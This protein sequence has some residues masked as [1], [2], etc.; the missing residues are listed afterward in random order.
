MSDNR[1]L[2][3][4]IE[5]NTSGTGA[6]FA[7]KAHE[8]GFAPVLVASDPQKYDYAD[9]PWLRLESCDTY[10]RGAL[11]QL[12]ARLSATDV[13]AGVFSS[14]EYFV[15]QAA[16][17]ARSLGLN[18]PDADR[19][20]ACRDKSV[21][22][23]T[24][25]DRGIDNLGF[26]LVGSPDEAAEWAA[27]RNGPV[28]VKPT[29]G[30][31]STGVKL[32]AGSLQVRGHTG[33]LLESVP[34]MPVLI[35]DFAPGQEYSV[36]IFDG[37]VCGLVSKHLGPTP[38][39][40]ECGHDFPARVAQSEAE[41]LGQF[42]EDCTDVLG[43]TWGPAH[44][45]LRSDGREIHLIEVNPRLAGGY[46]PIMI[47]QASGLYLIAATI[48]KAAGQTFK[49]DKAR[50]DSAALRFIVPD[51]NGPL[52]EVTGLERARA[53]PAVVSASLDRILPQMF[54]IS[55]DFHDRIGHLVAV[56]KDQPTAIAAVDQALACIALRF[57]D[58][59]QV[60]RRERAIQ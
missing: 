55:H 10:N 32:C 44:V 18:G 56:H 14:S 6:V 52:L 46:I 60:S 21:Q 30:S 17:L 43:I 48:L 25:A 38:H 54:E 39:F 5:S 29:R 51:R 12:A 28:V 36:E 24:V 7:Q 27:K 26:A 41:R 11:D 15:A 20:E 8:L 23:Q 50:S 34:D 31:G 13:I 40:V 33:A 45:E 59:T 42:A 37:K 35:E 19:I 2:F 53:L 22:R 9:A 1:P 49:L 58:E 4:F 57:A 16:A 3:L 47:R